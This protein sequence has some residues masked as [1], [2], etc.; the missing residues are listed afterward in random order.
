MATYLD[1]CLA[2][3]DMGLISD[4]GCPGI[5]DPGA[6]IVEQAHLQGIKVFGIQNVLK[7]RKK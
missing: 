4:A 6:A 5:A 1:P 2:G 7:K 3:I